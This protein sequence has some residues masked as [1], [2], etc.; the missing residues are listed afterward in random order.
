[1]TMTDNQKSAAERLNDIGRGA[2]ES[3]ADMVAALNVDYDRLEELRDERKNL[4]DMIDGVDDDERADAYAELAQWQDENGDEL[5][6]LEGEAGDCEDRDEA[7]RRIQEDALSVQVRSGWYAP[8]DKHY[9]TDH[10]EEFKILLNTGGP[11]TRIIGQLDEYNQ[12]C[13]AS[14]EAQDWF[15]PWTEYVNADQDV[16]LDYA[17]CFYYGD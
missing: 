8:G 7:E 6:E 16:L 5:A 10:P 15:L 9:A 3:I 1:M 13:S 2:Y 12:P 11:A 14:L 17:R 4:Q